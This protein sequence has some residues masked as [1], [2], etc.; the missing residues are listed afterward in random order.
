M[1][2]EVNTYPEV[3]EDGQ[4]YATPPNVVV[5]A[6][7]ER[8]KSPPMDRSSSITTDAVPLTPRF[9]IVNTVAPPFCHTSIVDVPLSLIAADAE[10]EVPI[11]MFPPLNV[12]S[13]ET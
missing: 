1:L 12:A 6:L 13:P 2:P 4:V 9:A 3:A 5:P 11:P 10:S 7:F 8:T